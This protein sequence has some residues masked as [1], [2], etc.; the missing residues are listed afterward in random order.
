L[1]EVARTAPEELVMALRDSGTTERDVAVSLLARGLVQVGD[2]DHPFWKSLRKQLGASDPALVTFVR[3]LD[4]TLSQKV[5]AQ[6]APR[7]PDG[8]EAVAPGTVPPAAG[9]ARTAETRPGG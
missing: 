8:A 3:S 4:A 1:R 6:K 2:A 9:A 5:A 7:S